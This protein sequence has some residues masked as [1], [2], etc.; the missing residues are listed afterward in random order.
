M[1]NQAMVFLVMTAVGFVAGI[2][3]DC[4]RIFRKLVRHGNIVSQIQDILFWITVSLLI[5]A[6]LLN[7]NSGEVRGFAVI[8][9][10]LGM[11]LYFFTLSS[12]FMRAIIAAI[13]AV[14]KI[15]LAV[16]KAIS[17][18]FKFIIKT[19]FK[20]L[21]PILKPIKKALSGMKK[22]VKIK[23]NANREKKKQKEKPEKKLKKKKTK[24]SGEIQQR[25]MQNGQK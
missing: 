13:K 14:K 1:S 25:R 21:R 3:Y 2:A 8:G 22:Y 4:L 19:I 10:L 6:V 7:L 12:L 24:K 18:P 11:I 9:C 23:K 15:I 17:A 16:I 5:F 20:L